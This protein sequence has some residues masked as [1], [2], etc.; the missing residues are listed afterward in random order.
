MLFKS[1]DISE[2]LSKYENVVVNHRDYYATNKRLIHF[3][4]GEF[5]DV[6]YKDII[7]VKLVRTTYARLGA[8]LVMIGFVMLVARY[9][10]G[11]LLL[12]SGV[13]FSFVKRDFYEIF[14]R[15][16]EE[17]WL[18]RDVDE[19]PAI[20][21]VRTV[22]GGGVK[23]ARGK[24]LECPACGA[25]CSSLDYF[26][27]NCGK[28]LKKE[29]PEVKTSFFMS[30]E[31][32]T[33]MAKEQVFNLIVGLDYGLGVTTKRIES[34]LII[35]PEYLSEAIDELIDEGRVKEIKKGRFVAVKS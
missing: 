33:R 34:H 24:I 4:K 19:E 18:I 25:S 1:K 7:S 35:V 13:L 5:E 6:L 32:K 2:Y 23:E 22:R 3:S 29:R 15:S 31:E 16:R 17:P 12:V 21:L 20:E 9:Y 26:C 27:S 28:L 30:Q 11:I 8:L 10:W 14:L